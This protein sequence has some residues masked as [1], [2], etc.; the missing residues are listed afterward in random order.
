MASQCAVL[1]IVTVCAD[2]LSHGQILKGSL[3]NTLSFL[4]LDFLCVV[5]ACVA[6]L[7]HLSSGKTG[8]NLSK[9]CTQYH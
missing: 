4:G 7:V 6:S 5:F 1:C 8:H 2:H 9:E 3:D